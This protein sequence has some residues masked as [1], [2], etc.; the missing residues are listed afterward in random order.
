MDRSTRGLVL[1]GIW[2]ALVPILVL[3]LALGSAFVIRQSSGLE[4]RT[5]ALPPILWP[6]TLMLLASS[7]TLELARRLLPVAESRA[8]RWSFVTLVL[9]GLFVI[10][11]IIAWLQLSGQ[12]VAQGNSP[13]AVFF[14]LL[15]GAHAL[16]LVG[17][18]IGL[19]VAAFLPEQGFRRVTRPLAIQ[20]AAIYW[21]F[22]AILWCG[23]LLLLVLIR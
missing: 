12:P 1:L 19:G 4:W 21:H 5:I 13:G 8:R 7:G 14:Y 18:L 20:V 6:N 9:G 2:I 3:F 10:G 23:V 16:H 17:G 22:M 11:Q 15:T